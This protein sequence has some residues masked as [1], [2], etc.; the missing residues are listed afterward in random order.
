VYLDNL[1]DAVILAMEKEEATGE[2]FNVVDP[3]RL[4]KRDY[5]NG[6]IR[7]VD[8][9]AKVLYFPYSLL[10]AMT[11]LQERALDLMNRRPGL[12]CYRL[13]SSQKSVIYDGSYI[14]QRL[15]WRPNVSVAT[16]MSGMV[17]AERSRT[18]GPTIPRASATRERSVGATQPVE[19][20][21]AR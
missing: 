8:P 6:V 4:T 13:I 3:E 9:A 12:S 1:I 10:Y 17:A 2:V 18:T 19:P 21:S 5:V 11:W 15:G 20:G 14:S 16:A 7:L